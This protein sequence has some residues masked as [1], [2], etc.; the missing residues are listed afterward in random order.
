MK[1]QSTIRQPDRLSSYFKA[2]WSILLAITIT[3]I[4]YNIG[5]LAG[6]WFEGQLAQCLLE[7]FGGTKEFPDMLRLVVAYVVL[8]A[9]VQFSRALKRLYVRRFANHIDRDMK[10]ILYGTLIHH[11]KAELESESIGNVITK[12]ISDVTT[13][14]E[15]MRKFTTEVF[16]T[17]V[18][19]AGYVVLLLTYDW[20]LALICLLF[21]PISYYIAEKLKVI[22]QRSS[23]KAQESRSRLNA[24][25]LDRVS[26][27][28][29][30]RV[31]G[32]ETQRNM[33]YEEQLSDY[34]KSSVQANIWV[35]A[36]PPLYRTISMISVLFIL[37]FGSR[38]VLGDGWTTWDIAAFT[39]FLSCFNKLAKKSSRAAN[40]FNAVQKAEVS[41]ENQTAHEG[42]GG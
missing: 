35:A 12:A 40:L 6:P 2:E 30:Y 19:L 24:A 32:C 17:G 7:I 16:D 9:V 15:G 38:N 8:I 42:C 11:S 25:T 26:N 27:A 10:R 22:V 28:S 23:A 31:F 3:G 5:M 33:A 18:A 20:R 39:T 21:P 13:C 41:Q 1:Q 4:L 36:M 34:E 37:Y 29:T 14:A